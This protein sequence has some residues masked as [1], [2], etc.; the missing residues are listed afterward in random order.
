MDS[1][2]KVEYVASVGSK[3]KLCSCIEGIQAVHYFRQYLEDLVCLDGLSLQLK[4]KLLRE[5]NKLSITPKV[6]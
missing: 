1:F 4:R 2:S 5:L 3:V 6:S